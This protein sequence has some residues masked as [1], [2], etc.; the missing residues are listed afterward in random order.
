MSTQEDCWAW[1]YERSGMFTVRSAYR[2]MITAKKSREDYF[3]GR[4][5]CSDVQK[6]RGNGNNCGI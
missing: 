2:M 1:H 4:T 3:D 6:Y 5:S